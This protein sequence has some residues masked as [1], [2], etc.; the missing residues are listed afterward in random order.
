MNYFVSIHCV[1]FFLSEVFEH[2]SKNLKDQQTLR[3]LKTL[4]VNIVHMW[5]DII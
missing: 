1:L 5:K 2:S 4:S 3:T